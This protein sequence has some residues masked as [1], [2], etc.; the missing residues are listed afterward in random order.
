M[1]RRKCPGDTLALRTIG[2]VLSTLIQ[3]FEWDRV[4]GAEIDMTE[5]G[6]LTIHAQGRPAGGHQ[7]A[8][9]SHVLKEL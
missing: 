9:R 8:A 5:G 2:L 4:D 6:G 1:P 3:C 7:Q